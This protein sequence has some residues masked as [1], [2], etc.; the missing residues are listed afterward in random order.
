MGLQSVEAWARSI[1]ST[2]L[3]VAVE[4]HDDGSEPGMY[5]LR[6]GSRDTPHVAIECTG[7]VDRVATETWNIGP[8]RGPMTATLAGDWMVE[9]RSGAQF[10]RITRELGPLLHFLEREGSTTSPWT[11]VSATV[12]SS[13]TT[14]SMSSVSPTPTVTGSTARPR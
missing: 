3:G 14:S 1:I 10:R 11:I 6:I 4:I 12:I 8:A 5:D 13:C 9:I 7:A 2:E